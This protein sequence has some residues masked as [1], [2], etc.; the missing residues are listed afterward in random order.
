MD[1]YSTISENAETLID[2]NKDKYSKPMDA[3]VAAAQGYGAKGD[4]AVYMG[5]VAY[6]DNNRQN[7]RAEAIQYKNEMRGNNKQI[8]DSQALAYVIRNNSNGCACDI[9][10]KYAD[11]IAKSMLNNGNLYNGDIRDSYRR[12]RGASQ[13]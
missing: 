4:T 10:P 7:I 6:A 2:E 5:N 8:T 9:N 12:N 13:L 3:Y 11:S 1:A